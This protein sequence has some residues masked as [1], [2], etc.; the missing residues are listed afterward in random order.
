[1]P[2]ATTPP[3]HDRGHGTTPGLIVRE[4]EPANL[5]SPPSSLGSFLT[6][7]RQ[8]YIRNHFKIPAIDAAS[9]RLK[10]EG[11]V[12]NPFEISLAELRELPAARKVALLECA[13]NG[14]VFLVPKAKGLLWGTG[15]VGNAEWVGVPLRVLL[16]RAGVAEGAVEVILE[17]ADSGEISAEPPTPGVIPYARSLDLGK[18]RADVLLAYA[19]NGASLTPGHGQPVRAVVPG[20]YGMASV[21]W[22]ARVVVTEQPFVGYFQSLEYSTFQV[23]HGLASLVPLTAN[24]VNSQILSPARSAVVAGG[25]ACPVR[26]VAWGGEATITR[27][28]FSPD[29]GATW[30][31]A[32]LVGESGRHTWRHWETTWNVPPRAGT[33][34]LLARAG[35]DQGGIQPLERDPNLRTYMIHHVIPVEVEVEAAAAATAAIE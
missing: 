21:K 35:D 20:W 8:F 17:G 32:R 29:D 19:M 4:S 11:A 13:G 25:Q 18:A 22:L 1:M 5:E 2:T 28:E 31:D 9:W 33:H 24:A 16:D 27:V 34:R 15:A 30:T 26:G 14:R 23:N 3:D 10:V 12:R 7:S 6:P